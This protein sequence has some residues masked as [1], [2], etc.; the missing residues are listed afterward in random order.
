MRIFCCKSHYFVAFHFGMTWVSASLHTIGPF[1]F[2]RFEPSS[3]EL[4]KRIHPF[5][6]DSRWFQRDEVFRKKVLIFGLLVAFVSPFIRHLVPVNCPWFG[7]A[8]RLCANTMSSRPWQCVRHDLPYRNTAYFN[9]R[10]CIPSS[11]Y[12]FAFCI[13]ESTW[14]KSHNPCQMLKHESKWWW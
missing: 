8:G 11:S 10:P 7:E 12:H 4:K 2:P 1:L 3:V 14:C 13:S 9:L 5:W 6:N